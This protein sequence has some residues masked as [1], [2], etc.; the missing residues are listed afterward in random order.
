MMKL[1][2]LVLRILPVVMVIYSLLPATTQAT[3]ITGTYGFSYSGFNAGAP[4]DP[5]VGSI[6]VTFDPAGGDIQEQTSGISLNSLNIPLGSAIGFSYV[7][8]SDALIFGGISGTVETVNG[9]DDFSFS[10]HG[11]STLT[12]SGMFGFAYSEAAF[13]GRFFTLQWVRWRLLCLPCPYHLL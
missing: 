1:R 4:V 7:T 5:V 9:G 2:H 10:I 6:T 12:P 11:D 13:P 8:S 3:P